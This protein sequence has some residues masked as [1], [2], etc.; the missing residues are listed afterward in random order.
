MK[1]PKKTVEQIV[2]KHIALRRVLDDIEKE[3]EEKDGYC[4]M[5]SLFERHRSSCAIGRI[6][7]VVREE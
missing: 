2:E 6:F 3:I 5:C 4:P 1:V 7:K